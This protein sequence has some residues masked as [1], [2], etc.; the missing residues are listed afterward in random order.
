MTPLPTQLIVQEALDMVQ[1]LA[2]G[3]KAEAL[4]LAHQIRLQAWQ[5]TSP[6]LASA[7]G[8]FEQALK[9]GAS[10]NAAIEAALRVFAAEIDAA[11]SDT[12]PRD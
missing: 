10:S 4:V 3:K 12:P 7:A 6:A 5:H 8:A 11:L 2:A 1:A 9:K